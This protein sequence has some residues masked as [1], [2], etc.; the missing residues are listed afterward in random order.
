MEVNYTLDVI[1]NLVHEN[2]IN[3]PE[4]EFFN[5][6]EDI[7]RY[8]A[9]LLLGGA[10]R[11]QIQSTLNEFYIQNPSQTVTSELTELPGPSGMFSFL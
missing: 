4:N 2:N 3:E 9:S 10:L 6:H 11:K 1:K 8:Q 5:E 7:I